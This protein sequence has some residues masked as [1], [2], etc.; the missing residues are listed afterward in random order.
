MD[1]IPS[2]SGYCSIIFTVFFKSYDLIIMVIIF[3]KNLDCGGE[4]SFYSV[5]VDIYSVLVQYDSF[6]KNIPEKLFNNRLNRTLD[7]GIS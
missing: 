5:V 2:K 1:K 6:I 7:R 3:F 4:V